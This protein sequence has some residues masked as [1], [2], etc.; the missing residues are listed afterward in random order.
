MVMKLVIY[1][2]CVLL[3][4]NVHALIPIEGLI[5]GNVIDMEQTDPLQGILSYTSGSDAPD[6]ESGK[7]EHFYSIYKQGLDL[8][9]YCE[10]D[11][12]LRYEN[13]WQKQSAARSVAATLQYLGIDASLKAITGYAK[14]L[15]FSEDKFKTLVD[16]L[17]KSSCSKNITV[18]SLKLIQDNFKYEWDK[19]QDFKLPNITNSPFYSTYLKKRQNTLE[20]SKR[21]LN[22]SLRNF[23]AFCSWNGDVADYRL[24]V[25]YL[26]NPFI[27]TLVNNNLRQKRLALDKK[28]REL[29]LEDNPNSV[30]VACDSM[31]CRKRSPAE[32][33]RL[34]PHIIGSTRL[35]DDLYN[36][37]CDHFSKVRLNKAQINPNIKQWIE[38]SS[39]YAGKVEA[40]HFL[41]YFTGVPD[42][43]VTAKKFEDI[44]EY[45]KQN[46]KLRWDNWSDKKLAL[47]DNDHLYEEPLEIRLISQKGTN[48]L[49]EGKFNLLFDVGLSEIDRVLDDVDKIDTYFKLKFSIKYL[50]Y[51]RDQH[52]F[53]QKIGDTT[54][55]EN[56]KKDLQLRVKTQLV[57]KQKYFKVK[58]WTEQMPRIISDELLN[59]LNY[60]L[61]NE[62]NKLSKK[63]VHIPVK[64]RFGIFAL[65]Y[66]NQ[67]YKFKQ[68]EKI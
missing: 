20:V 3:S 56:L 27:M 29:V 34:F 35:K 25:P 31:I 67:R 36:L 43:M 21:E 40:L 58:I 11:I 47:F 62:L 23:R 12:L 22:Y 18:Y 28:T 63:T 13:D 39:A 50:A 30:Q 48:E 4:S 49:L 17:I 8:K 60:Y 24:L 68:K 64:F 53:Y 37:Y 26:K 14:K 7:L 38:E 55:L 9:N 41:S 15:E 59:Q 5:Y 6:I 19:E 54:K 66:I 42:P 16:N 46:I 52:R 1:F 32:F 10:Q 65:R 44:P 61:G 2:L 57:H 45:L 51:L 33:K